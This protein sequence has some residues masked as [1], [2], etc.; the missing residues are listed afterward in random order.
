MSLL[1]GFLQNRIPKRDLWHPG[2]LNRES[3][4]ETVAQ[5]KHDQDGSAWEIK[6]I[7]P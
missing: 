6:T 5:D 4:K 1:E 7:G 2:S 3:D